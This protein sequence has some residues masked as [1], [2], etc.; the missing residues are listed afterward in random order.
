MVRWILFLGGIACLFVGLPWEVACAFSPPLFA[1]G[2]VLLT[3]R[4]AS[5][6]VL[7]AWLGATFLMDGNVFLA[8]YQLVDQY[9]LPALQSKW[10]LCV[11]IFTFVLGA[12]AAVLEKGGGM[13]FFAR[14]FVK[15]NPAQEKLSQRSFS[16]LA[17]GT[18][19]FCFF[20]GLANSMLVG[21]TMRP[22]ADR[23][24]VSREKLAYI[25]DSTSSAVACVAIISTWIAYQLSMIK[26]GYAQRGMEVGTFDLFLSSLPYNFYCWGTLVVMFCVI[27]FSV[28]VGPMK[29]AEERARRVLTLPGNQEE[30]GLSSAKWYSALVPICF[31]LCSMFVG[32]YIS[33]REHGR[34]FSIDHLRDAFGRADAGMVL[35][36]VSILSL[37][38]ALFVQPKGE[39]DSSY[40]MVASDGAKSL[41]EPLLILLSA[42]LLSGV[43]KDLNT[44]SLLSSLLSEQM[45]LRW[46]GMAVFVIGALIS[47]FTGTSWGTMGVLMPLALPVAIDLSLLHYGDAISLAPLTIGAVFSGAVFGDHCSPLSD[48]T[49]VSSIACDVTPIEHVRTQMPYALFTAVL[50]ATVGFGLIGFGISVWWC[51]IIWMAILISM[52]IIKSLLPN[53]EHEFLS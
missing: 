39:K 46:W 4:V 2:F 14:Y 8:G 20:D 11:L 41:F 32:L 33:G 48:T 24:G 1:V 47:F 51:W 12:F 5:S 21:K 16:L 26:E 52:I 6:L 15:G 37:G 17:Y 23:F 28:H 29:S 45:S 40:L 44:A 36:L 35:V 43:L 10:N 3:K 27:I 53:K 9:L 18:G 30:D 31:L 13:L 38:V 19:I 49:I 25:T 34:Q 22:L 7:G 42:W 50:S